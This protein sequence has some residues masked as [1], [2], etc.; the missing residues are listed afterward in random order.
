MN[1]DLGAVA[2][3][4]GALGGATGGDERT[5]SSIA[6]HASSLAARTQLVRATPS[7]HHPA[8]FNAH[9]P[10]LWP[11]LHGPLPMLCRPSSTS[12][13]PKLSLLV[14]LHLIELP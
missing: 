7:P 10:D 13:L 14:E 2:D 11:E 1:A 9:S 5:R 6:S 4:R 12:P 3:G 8:S